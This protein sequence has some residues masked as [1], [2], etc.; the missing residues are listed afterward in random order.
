MPYSVADYRGLIESGLQDLLPCGS[1]RGASRLNSAIRYA[2][3][4]G[5]KRMRPMLA[6]MGAQIV[7][8]NLDRAMPA[9]CATEFLHAASLIF[10]DLPAMDDADVRRGRP[11]LHLAFGEDIALLTALALLNQSYAIFGRTPALIREAT[12]CIGVDGMIG[13]QAVDLDI[14]TA[15]GTPEKFDSRNRKTTALMRLTLTAGAIACG[16]SDR[17]IDALARC[18]EC[19]GEAYQIYDDLVD[20]FGRCEETGKTANQDA[21]HQ[22]PSHVLEFGSD[23]SRN[24]VASLVAESKEVLNCCFGETEAVRV[25]TTA[26]DSIVG[27]VSAAGLVTA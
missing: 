2:I 8:G 7:K 5:G 20:Q 24:H 3:F 6:L 14:R 18:G 4:P 12:E 23:A 21:R 13:G 26:I 10:D 19:L 27:K 15:G 17:D 16:A 22:R 1:V 9:A 11:A 25:L